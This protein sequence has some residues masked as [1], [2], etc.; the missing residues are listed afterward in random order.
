MA[1]AVAADGRARGGRASLRS[2]WGRSNSGSSL[3]DLGRGGGR[4]HGLRSLGQGAGRYVTGERKASDPTGS[5]PSVAARAGRRITTDGCRTPSRRQVAN[6]D[7]T[8]RRRSPRPVAQELRL[9]HLILVRNRGILSLHAC[10]YTGVNSS[11]NNAGRK[12]TSSRG[13]AAVG[14]PTGDHPWVRGQREGRT[15]GR[16]CKSCVFK[17]P[18]SSSPTASEWIRISSSPSGVRPPRKPSG[19][20]AHVSCVRSAW[21]TPSRT[22]RS[23]ASGEA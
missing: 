6:G 17:I 1:T 12:R 14:G 3:L 20:A 23:S 21:S 11:V 19:S 8:V 7:G 13:A 4:I 2:W 18:G 5:G 10:N 22:A 15:S 16:L 9:A